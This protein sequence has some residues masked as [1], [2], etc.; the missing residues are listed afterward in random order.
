M[1]HFYLG[2]D[3]T[4]RNVVRAVCLASDDLLDTWPCCWSSGKSLPAFQ[5]FWIANMGYQLPLVAATTATGHDPFEVTAWLVENG[6]LIRCYHRQELYDLPYLDSE[7]ELTDLPKPFH[8]AYALALR[9]AY[10]NEASFVV[11]QMLRE[12]RALRG[13]IR[14][15]E[16]AAF[17]LEQLEPYLPC[18]F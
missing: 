15:L 6:V 8:R 14:A 12:I 7:A 5:A 9:V 11:G 2:I 1:S 4:Q 10:D 3:N 16:Q 13:R 18:P 17:R